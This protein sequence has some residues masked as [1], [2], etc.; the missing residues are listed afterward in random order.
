[1]SD[2]LAKLTPK[3]L[4]EAL[5]AHPHPDLPALAGRT[6]HVRAGVLVPLTWRAE[7]GPVVVTTVRPKTMR[8]H[9]GEV[10][11]P[12]GRP[13]PG[14]ADLF[15]TAL[16][17]AREE[18]GIQHATLLGR[19]SSMPLYTSDYRLEP[20]VA[21]VPDAPL[22]PNPGEVAEVV[23]IPIAEHMAGSSIDAIPWEEDGESRLSPVFTLGPHV[24]YGGTA[25]VFYELLLVAAKALGVELPPLQPGRYRWEDLLPH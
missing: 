14:D 4:A 17:E 15:A 16:R 23:A 20:F 5:A 3:A 1:L 13:D 12:G 9:A 10:C 8:M 21:E 11:F 6:N 18:V 2:P 19:L 22:R 25:H 7:A 24:M